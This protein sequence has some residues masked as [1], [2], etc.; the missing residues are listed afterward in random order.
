MKRKGFT[1]IE[2][3]VVIT[4]IAMLIAILLP[5]LFGAM[6]LAR[7]VACANN[8]SQIG[9]ACQ[10]Y[11][12]GFKQKWP[13]VLPDSGTAVPAWAGIG[14]TRD[15]TTGADI[16]ATTVI[17]SNTANF[18]LLV[19]TG[20]AE[21]PD[22]FVCPSQSSHSG[23]KSVSDYT[24][25]RDFWKPENVSY[26]Y[27]NVAGLYKLS[28]AAP[29]GL[30]VAADVN[31][32]RFDQ[33]TAVATYASA[34]VNYE[35]PGWGVIATPGTTKWKLN[36]PNHRFKGQNVLYLDGHVDFTNNPYCGVMYDNIWTKATTTA[37]NPL[38]TDTGATLTGKLEAGAATAS[39]NDTTG[40]AG[41]TVLDVS[42]RNDSFLVP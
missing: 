13:D 7:R 5:A 11:A 15:A 39:Y 25:V 26:S 1:L 27:Q 3:L 33:S 8:L 28:S 4:I 30:A 16:P 6:E 17:N 10:A 34:T 9:K 2:L 36:S 14:V 42:A 12:A 29:P 40:L 18:W 35:T 21:N 31:P 32:Q 37:V 41:T 23:D 20:M 19:R 22:V 38:P 24:T